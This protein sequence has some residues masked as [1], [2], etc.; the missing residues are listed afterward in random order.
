[1]TAGLPKR[2]DSPKGIRRGY[3]VREA[4]RR[5]MS[6]THRLAW[7]YRAR[8]PE[9]AP[10]PANAP[11]EPPGAAVAAV[12]GEPRRCSRCRAVFP[13]LEERNAAGHVVWW[14]CPPCRE[15]LLG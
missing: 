10:S 13:G 7:G 9:P 14:L 4:V 11:I 3:R 15:A 1:M 2:G 8:V 12:E 6:A 5:A